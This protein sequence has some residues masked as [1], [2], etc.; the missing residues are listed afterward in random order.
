MSER[1]VLV[2]YSFDI[3]PN[4]R[5]VPMLGWSSWDLVTE[6]GAFF[7]SGPEDELEFNGTDTYG[8]LNFEFPVTDVLQTVASNVHGDYDIGSSKTTRLGIKFEF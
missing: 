1:G 6:E 4:F 5:I 8:R 7:N 3:H 2:G